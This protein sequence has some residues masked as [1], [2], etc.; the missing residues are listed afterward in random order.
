MVAPVILEL[1]RL[2]QKDMGFFE[3]EEKD[4]KYEMAKM[5]GGE[6]NWQSLLLLIFLSQ[7]VRSSS[8]IEV[9]IYRERKEQFM[10]HLNHLPD[11]KQQ[12]QGYSVVGL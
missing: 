3:G 2:K 9:E 4:E 1:G 11:D 8:Q 12:P 10:W 7:E 6:G 5:C